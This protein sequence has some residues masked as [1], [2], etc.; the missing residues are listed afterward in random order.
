MTEARKPG[1]QPGNRSAQTHGI[2]S[3]RIQ[4]ERRKRLHAKWRPAVLAMKPELNA[5]EVMLGIDIVS[6]LDQVIDWMDSL[7]GPFTRTGR[8]RTIPSDTKDR[9]LGR[10]A[11]WCRRNGVGISRDYQPAEKPGSGSIEELLAGLTMEN[12]Q[13]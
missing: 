8:H 4:R 11:E 9:L 7:G 3:P 6:D 1:G 10:W 2:R 5:V 12:W 13:R